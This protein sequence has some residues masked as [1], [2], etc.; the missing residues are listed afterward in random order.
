VD[1]IQQ[2]QI[3][4]E[5]EHQLKKQ[6]RALQNTSLQ[7]QKE[8]NLDDQITIA[9]LILGLMV[10]IMTGGSYWLAVVGGTEPKWTATTISLIVGFISGRLSTSS[11]NTA[12]AK[13]K[14]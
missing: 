4:A 3:S 2:E 11:T 8:K 10:L 7:S 1:Q 6:I 5:V 9:L 14:D 12:E 13:E